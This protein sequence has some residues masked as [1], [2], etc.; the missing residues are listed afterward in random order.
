MLREH[1]RADV[2]AREASIARFMAGL[3]AFSSAAALAL[4]PIIGR[5][6]ALGIAALTGGLCVYYATT[7]RLIRRGGFHPVMQWINTFVMV[8]IPSVVFVLDDKFRGPVYALT[9][10]PLAAWGALIALTALRARRLLAFSGAALAAFEYLGLYWFLARPELPAEVPPTLTLPLIL[11]RCVFLFSYGPLTANMAR[12]LVRKAE[13]ALKAIRERD[14]MGKYFLHERIGAGGM[15]EVFRATY[16]PEGGFE[17]IVAVKRVLPAYASNDEFLSMFRREAELCAMLHHPNV[18][19][20]FDLG[21]HRD[22]VFLAMEFVEGFSLDSLLRR[23][24]QRRLPAAAVA[25]LGAELGG[26]LDYVHSRTTATGEPLGLVHRDINPPNILVSRIGEVKL[27]DFGIARAMTQLQVTM[28][29][30]TRGKAGYMSPEQAQSLPLD[31]RSDLFALGLTLH[32]ALTGNRALQGETD[33]ELLAASVLQP[34][35][36]PSTLVPDVPPELD[37]IVMALL[38][39]DRERRT[40]SGAVLQ[41]Q[42]MQ[43]P[44]YV[45]PYPLGKTQLAQAMQTP[46]PAAPMQL[47]ENMALTELKKP[48][49]STRLFGSG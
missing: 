2:S 7:L 14:M 43:L 15:A 26:A 17:R 24:P 49:G 6:L 28:A 4:I 37:A 40:P 11:V 29:G 33:R 10:P 8:S 5:Q 35:A 16:S 44:A 27:S 21:R 34:V 45:N 31:G 9:A 41:R 46:A 1:L 18:V 22:V 42:L 3:T 47:T 39:P 48:A 23:L 38:Q 12:H 30:A 32:E 20:V 36:R 13:E 19:Q 25:Y